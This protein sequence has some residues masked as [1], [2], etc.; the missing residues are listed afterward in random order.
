M[1]IL[2]TGAN[3]MLAKEVKEKFQKNNEIIA[4]DVQELDITDEKAVLDFVKNTKPDYIINCA[5]YT[6]VDKAED[7]YELAD[8]I[9][10]D[11]PTNLAKAAKNVGA[12]LVHISTDYVFGGNLDI[13][14]DY[15]D[16]DEKAT[17][18][19]YGKTKLHVEQGIA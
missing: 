15:K 12:K 14:K 3:G 13:S 18:T 2:V 16:D 10:G 6:A 7:N 5:A 1:R 8:R 11:G 19:A 4:T 9:N 17:V